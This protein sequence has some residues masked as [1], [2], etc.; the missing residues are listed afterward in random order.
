MTFQSSFVQD[1]EIF[2]INIS[3]YC[4]MCLHLLQNLLS[5]MIKS[6]FF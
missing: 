6:K 1:E 2:L 4:R 3:Q 5:M